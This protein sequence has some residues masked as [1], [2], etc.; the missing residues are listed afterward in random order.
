MTELRIDPS[1]ELGRAALEL[2]AR[3]GYDATSLQDVADRV[4]YTKANV[5]YHFGSKQGLFEAAL[6]PALEA[7]EALTSEF[8]ATPDPSWSAWAT[9]MIE[10]LIEHRLAVSI[11]INQAST[12]RDQPLVARANARI[13]ELESTAVPACTDPLAAMRHRVAMAGAAY[14]IAQRGLDGAPDDGLDDAAFCRVLVAA[15][16]AGAGEA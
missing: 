13:F 3:D 12:M 11:F 7:F 9:G 4:G 8:A 15:V 14:C 1:V 6:T 2:F 5:L 16:L 10:F